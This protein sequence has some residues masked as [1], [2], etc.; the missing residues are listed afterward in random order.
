MPWFSLTKYETSNAVRKAISKSR[1]LLGSIKR[2]QINYKLIT[3]NINN[4][5]NQ[6]NP[7]F[8][9]LFFRIAFWTF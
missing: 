2:L 5:N 4:T 1:W 9:G 6:K 8:L 3:N 7:N